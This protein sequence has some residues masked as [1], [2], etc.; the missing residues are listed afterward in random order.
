MHRSSS[1]TR[2]PDEDYMHAPPMA[3]N[4]LRTGS[5]QGSDHDYELPAYDPISNMIRKDKPRA[6]FSENAV[7]VIPFVLL[8]CA[9]ILWLFSGT[10]KN[11]GT[12]FALA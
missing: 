11:E 12:L 5:F 3:S 10:G 6:K 2:T 4:I 7:H 8:L 9:V 1:W